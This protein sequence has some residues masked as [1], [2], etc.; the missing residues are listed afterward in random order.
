MKLALKLM[1]LLGLSVLALAVDA[2]QPA[3]SSSPGR[4]A[5]PLKPVDFCSPDYKNN[6]TEAQIVDLYTKLQSA[7]KDYDEIYS[8]VKESLDLLHSSLKEADSHTKIKKVLRTHEIRVCTMQ[9]MIL[10]ILE[11]SQEIGSDS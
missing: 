11:S 9:N 5:S 8:M 1:A 10:N 7:F 3:G 6:P 2:A 4:P